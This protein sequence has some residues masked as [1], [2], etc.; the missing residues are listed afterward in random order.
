M[1]FD[2]TVSADTVITLL[3]LIVAYVG[4]KE[5][6]KSSIGT[7][8][9]VFKARRVEQLKIAVEIE[10]H[11]SETSLMISDFSREIAESENIN[12]NDL[13]HFS[14][15]TERYL[16][17]IDMLCYSVNKKYLDNEEDWKNK[18]NEMI[19]NGIKEY[20]EYYGEASPYK[21]TK[22]VYRRWNNS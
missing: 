7:K 1:F 16:Y 21:N 13:F 6:I 9:D 3:A 4:I 5:Q 11:I 10:K 8:E 22:E 20:E 17:A 18:Y 19:C 14:A 15:L 2:F 12:E